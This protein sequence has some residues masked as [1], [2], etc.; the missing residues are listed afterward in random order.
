MLAA[1]T[2]PVVRFAA[3][4][5]AAAKTGFLEILLFED[6]ISFTAI[7]P[8]IADMYLK[9]LVPAAGKKYPKNAPIAADG[10]Y[11]Q[12]LPAT[13]ASPNGRILFA[14]TPLEAIKPAAAKQI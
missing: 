13:I 7:I 12:G 10:A 4:P 8:K 11:C 1:A 14:T 9:W 6:S 5:Q 3:K 2:I